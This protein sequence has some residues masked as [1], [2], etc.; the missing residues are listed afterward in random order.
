MIRNM[1]KANHTNNEQKRKN[2]PKEKDK[3]KKNTKHL[4]CFFFTGICRFLR[5]NNTHTYV[6]GVLILIPVRTTWSHT[7]EYSIHAAHRLCV[8]KN[9]FEF[10][11]CVHLEHFARSIVSTSIYTHTHKNKYILKHLR[12]KK[13]CVFR[14]RESWSESNDIRQIFTHEEEQQ[15][16]RRNKLFETDTKGEMIFYLVRGLFFGHT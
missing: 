8:H 2:K 13:L 15:K 9:C 6:N 12:D 1:S 3:K 11:F 16:K 10:L 5:K 4:K 14:N 7:I